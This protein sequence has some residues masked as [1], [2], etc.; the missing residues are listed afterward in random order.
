LNEAINHLP[1]GSTLQ[2]VR[3]AS[4]DPLLNL[5]TAA[6]S[7]APPLAFI[8]ADGSRFGYILAVKIRHG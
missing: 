4:V 5:S 7:T 2:Y 8:V 6:T 3:V 1:T